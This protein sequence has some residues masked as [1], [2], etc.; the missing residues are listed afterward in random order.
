MSMKT[1]MLRFPLTSIALVLGSIVVSGALVGHINVIQVTAGALDGIAPN[2]VDDVAIVA[3][4]TALAFI[5]D[6]VLAARRAQ[7]EIIS[8]Q[9]ERLRVVQVTMR[10]VQDIVN[11]CLTQLQLV[12]FEAEGLVPPESLALFDDAIHDTAAKL[13]VLGDLD[14]YAEHQMAAGTGLGRDR[15]LTTIAP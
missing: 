3:V 14:T 9:I 4:L 12:R 10:T 8:L 13:K 6:H 7:H 5:A 15:T 11:N 1:P 2:E